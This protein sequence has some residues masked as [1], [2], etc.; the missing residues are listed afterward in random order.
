[1]NQIFNSFR[2]QPS[3]MSDQVLLFSGLLPPSLAGRDAL[4]ETEEL[5]ELFIHYWRGLRGRAWP[6]PQLESTEALLRSDN[7][8]ARL[9]D[10]GNEFLTVATDDWNSHGRG[11]RVEI[12]VPNVY[13]P[14]ALYATLLR[15]GAHSAFIR[16]EN[17]GEM[18]WSWP[19]RIGLAGQ[20][21]LFSR[22]SANSSLRPLFQAY[23][24]DRAPLRLNLLL[25]EMSLAE[26][27]ASMEQ[28]RLRSKTDSVVILGG[29]GN[30]DA[31]VWQLL[32]N[33]SVSTG[34][35]GVFI[36]D[37]LE[38]RHVQSCGEQLITL[39]SH[40]L[41]IDS[42]AAALSKAF[43]LPV[44]SWA[45]R[46][47][48]EATSVREQGRMLA[49]RLREMGDTRLRL[50]SD[51]F[52]LG[53]EK[54]S[55]SL[56]SRGVFDIDRRTISAKRISASELAD[57]VERSLERPGE[58]TVG[59]TPPLRF[60][61]ESG[62]AQSV[63]ALT[64]AT[65]KEIDLDAARREERQL[66]ARVETPEG[67]IITGQARM[68]QSTE[69][70]ASV[71]I[72]A[73]NPT[74]I[75]V[76]QPFKSPTPDSP[77]LLDVL[78]WESPASPEPQRAQLALPVHGDTGVARFPFKTAAD[79]STFSARIAVY[80][81]NRNLQTG[82]LTG[83]VGNEPAALSF[84]P[85]ATPLTK[86]V[87]LT[88]R[89]GIDASIILNDDASGNMYAYVKSNGAAA[90]VNVSDEKPSLE[91]DVD[92][93][94]EESLVKIKEALGRAITRITT[95]PEDYS[96]LSKEGSQKLL[97]ELAKR[98]SVLRT[99]LQNHSLMKHLFDDVKYIQIVSAH[100]DAFFPI[101]YLYDGEAPENQAKLCDGPESACKAL[102]SGECCGAVKDND[103]GVI[104]PLRF[105]SLNKVI[106]RHAHL[107][108]HTSLDGKFQLRSDPVSGRNKL[109]NPLRC[110]V[111][112]ASVDADASEKDT[113]KNLCTDLD[114]VLV[115][116]AVPATDWKSWIRNVEQLHPNLLVLLP[117]HEQELGS[118]LLE[119]GGDKLESTL[120]KA[121][122]VKS[123][124]DPDARPI[125]LLMGCRTDSAKIDLEGFVPAFQ[126][127]GAVIIVSTIATILGRHAGPAAAAIVQE[128]KKQ[129]GN[130]E[131]TFGDVMLAVRRR[132]L[133]AG[134][135]MV[136]GLT[137]YG[138]ADWRI[139]TG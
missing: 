129:E 137:S 1:M 47:L 82:L 17:E 133:A 73:I 30:T 101:E 75:Q 19:L 99:R 38:L 124:K 34:A 109:L 16:R 123:T 93:S 87:G 63:A 54:R 33:L 46:S 88:D 71:F 5:R 26:F 21:T 45:T 134:V 92:L 83:V 43:N 41:P 121:K 67:T 84:S 91:V 132:L 58:K 50:P 51:A 94:R 25:S 14:I 56:Q 42:A 9:I 115:N 80:H 18:A 68:L 39:L 86:F 36:L 76:H 126:D 81:G 107:P 35:Q 100:V 136:L 57:N 85:D 108:E 10:A 55:G 98:G 48:V 130:A 128:L 119:I 32:S 106:E 40:D 12:N 105:W 4:P 60:D 79:Q 90:A 125:V 95:N 44:L 27:T 110:A 114:N 52:R 23:D 78:F 122:H 37:S 103:A 59:G 96:D 15:A 49:R 70:V 8:V 64:N 11:L 97:L 65:S 31:P 6:W 62:G 139:G 69:Y 116:K 117:H 138:D 28:R 111:L 135:P 104:C 113:V 7:N 102:L 89:A 74:Y 24:Y 3:T 77:V 120:I 29:L 72:G 53:A 118:D 131:A 20:S 112:G 61:S 13:D 127:A 22:V 2:A 66:Q